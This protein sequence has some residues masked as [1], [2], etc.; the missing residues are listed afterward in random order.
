MRNA[1]AKNKRAPRL[2]TIAR[3]N[4]NIDCSCSIRDR[5]VEQQGALQQCRLSLLRVVLQG[6][7]EAADGRQS[8]HPV[9][10]ERSTFACEICAVK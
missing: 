9:T 8:I 7:Q 2:H 3:A 10:P 4:A 1:H 6:L 5:S